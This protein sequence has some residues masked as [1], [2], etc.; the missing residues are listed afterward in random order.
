M[1]PD[2]QGTRDATG[3]ARVAD[4]NGLEHE[5]FVGA[6]GDVFENSPWVAEAVWTRRPFD[7]ADDLHSR[8]MAVVHA[9]PRDQQVAFLNL[10]PELGG[11]DPVAETLTKD[12]AREQSGAGLQ[13]LTTEEASELAALNAAYR[14]AHGYPFI[15]AVSGL[16]KEAVFRELRRR[17]GNDGDIE[18][19]E[20]LAQIAKIT[21]MRLGRMLDD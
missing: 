15:L 9:A 18:F 20:A 12:S 6:L 19:A 2:R 11:K 5:A 14:K 13:A 7:S 10:H 4:L 3:R 21:R 1:T 8:M 16:D 17:S